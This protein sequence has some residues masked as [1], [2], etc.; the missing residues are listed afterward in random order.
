NGDASVHEPDDVAHHAERDPAFGE[1]WPLLDVELEIRGESAD[2]ALRL[3]RVAR[4]V[5]RAQRVRDAH[6][7]LVGA[8]RRTVRQPAERRARAEETDPEPRTLFITPADD[9]HR[10]LEPDA[11]VEQ[12]ND[13]LDGAEHA[14]RAVEATTLRDRVD[15][16]ADED[17][18]STVVA[19][20]PVDVRGR[21]APHG[22]A[23]RAKPAAHEVAR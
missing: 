22:R 20:S 2:V 6:P 7:V 1:P 12:G 17:G 23:A 9:L 3:G 11:V 8:L 10:T 21:I 14:Q 13:R 19:E 5:D 18:R 16:R 15:V 4:L